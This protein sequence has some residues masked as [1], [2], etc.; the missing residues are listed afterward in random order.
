[1]KTKIKLP[2]F[3]FITACIIL[4]C[5]GVPSC[6]KT[7]APLQQSNNTSVVSDAS[8]YST[9]VIDKWITMQLRL[10][11]D[12]VGIPNVAFA[13][14]Y[15]YSG[16]AAFEALAP[17]IM[18]KTPSISGRWNGLNTS[19]LMRPDLSLE[20]YWPA[21]V[22]TALAYIKQEYVYNSQQ[23]KQQLIL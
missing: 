4:L 2:K 22:N 5:S 19:T 20:F 14:Y 11:R 15:A 3:T 7:E 6:K 21:S 9:D 8:Q 13:R 23:I 1:M 16:V 12:A 10:D 18:S 17:G